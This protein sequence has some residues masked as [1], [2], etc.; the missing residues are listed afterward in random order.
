ML[1]TEDST[2]DIVLQ[3]IKFV[4]QSSGMSLKV[5]KL[6]LRYIQLLCE[7]PFVSYCFQLHKI[8]YIFRT[9]S[10]ILMRFLAKQSSLNAFI[11]KLK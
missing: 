8:V 3:M 10:L 9:V 7:I 4:R 6:I 2:F 5:G 11:N 1:S